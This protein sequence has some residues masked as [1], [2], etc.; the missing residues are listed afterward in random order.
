MITEAPTFA[1]EALNCMRICFSFLIQVQL[2]KLD[3][4]QILSV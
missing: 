4:L 3:I 1:K 2:L